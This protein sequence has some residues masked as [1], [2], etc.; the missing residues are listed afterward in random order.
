MPQE[1][2]PYALNI[3]L[4]GTRTEHLSR[5]LSRLNEL[6]GEHDRAGESKTKVVIE[7]W[8]EEELNIIRRQIELYMRQNKIILKSECYIKA[9]TVRPEPEKTPM[10]EEL[11]RLESAGRRMGADS[12]EFVT[13]PT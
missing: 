13:R 8:D 7:S 3:S 4:E 10:E 12:V 1:K 6:C 5:V 11:E 2:P 9:P